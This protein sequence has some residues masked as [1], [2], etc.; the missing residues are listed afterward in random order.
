MSMWGFLEQP[1]SPILESGEKSEW[2]LKVE[3]DV[4][5]LFDAM[6]RDIERNPL[7]HGAVLRDHRSHLTSACW[8]EFSKY[9]QVNEGW[10]AVRKQESEYISVYHFL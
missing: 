4:A 6:K 10:R 2:A 8:R 1:Q 9:V 7:E 5:T 3:S